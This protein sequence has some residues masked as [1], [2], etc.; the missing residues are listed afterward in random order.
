MKMDVDGIELEILQGGDI[1]LQNPRV[2][3]LMIEGEDGSDTM[4]QIEVF[5]GGKG[6][7][8]EQ[9]FKYALAGEEGKYA[10]THNF[11]FQLVSVNKTAMIRPS[12]CL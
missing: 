10:R 4:G 6:F 3:D 5:L 11:L 9:K 2:R 8:L 7:A 12:D 1:L